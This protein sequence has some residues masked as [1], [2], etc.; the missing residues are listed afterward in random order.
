MDLRIIIN[1]QFPEIHS[2]SLTILQ[3]FSVLKDKKADVKSVKRMG[4][5]RVSKKG[6]AIDFDKHESDETLA[7][8]NLMVPNFTMKMKNKQQWLSDPFFASKGGYKMCLRVDAAG[9]GNDRGKHVSV[10][11][12]VMKGPSYN[13]VNQS[14]HNPV[15]GYVVIELISQAMVIPH[16]LRVLTLN[17]HSCSTCINEVNKS[18]G[19]TWLGF[20]DFVSVESVHAY[21]LKDDSLHFRVSY[22]EHF[23]YIDAMLLYIPNVP[24][25]LIFTVISSIVIYLILIS[26]EFVAFCTEEES[27]ALISSC[28]NFNIGSIKTFLLTKQ[29][30]LLSTWYVAIYS[31]VWEFL[32]YTL[33]VVVEVALITVGELVLWDMSTAS[34][35]ILPTIMAVQRVSIVVVFSMIVNQYMMSWGGQIIMV[36]PLWLIRAYSYSVTNYSY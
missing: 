31:T 18:T 34:D 22:S 12:Q 26:I 8:L 1:L 27:N 6:T 5:G 25:V 10:F 15:D 24:A 36:H 21:Y 16:N 20:S 13:V 30:V 11:L 4:S 19:A 35:N 17:N 23:W 32:K 7:P 33:T 28:S 29:S 9:E 2:D 3:N 14:G